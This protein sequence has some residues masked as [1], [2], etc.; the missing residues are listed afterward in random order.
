MTVDD[1]YDV[2]WKELQRNLREEIES[3]HAVAMRRLQ[4]KARAASVSGWVAIFFG[5]LSMLLA[6]L[7]FTR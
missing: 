5:G 3:H 4:R 2:E 6:W 1:D 7:V